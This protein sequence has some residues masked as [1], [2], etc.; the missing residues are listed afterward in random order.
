MI[1]IV[2][3]CL[4]TEE[5]TFPAFFLSSNRSTMDTMILTNFLKSAINHN[6]VDINLRDKM[7]PKNRDF[8]IIFKRKNLVKTNFFISYF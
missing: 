1:F 2:W 4:V 5:L 8:K 6:F 7:F 3:P